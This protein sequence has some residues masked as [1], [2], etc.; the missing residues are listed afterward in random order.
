MAHDVL[1]SNSFPTSPTPF[2]CMGFYRRRLPTVHIRVNKYK[3]N[4]QMSAH[5]AI[6]HVSNAHLDHFRHTTQE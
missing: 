1:I 4:K 5:I 6:L 3:C 2:V